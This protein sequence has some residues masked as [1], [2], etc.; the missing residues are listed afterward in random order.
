MSY[1]VTWIFSVAGLATG[2]Y[3]SDG[4]IDGRKLFL[5]ALGGGA[6]LLSH[7]ISA[8]LSEGRS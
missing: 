7:A 6:A 1:I 8:A 4:Y 3:L 5:M 2:S